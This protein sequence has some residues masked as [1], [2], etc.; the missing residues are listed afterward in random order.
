MFVEALTYRMGPHTT[1]DDPTRYRDDAEL[2]HWRARDPIDRVRRYLES[3]GTDSSTFA[4]IDA[5]AEE[6]GAAVR[7]ACL[8]I[9]EPD[10]AE[11]F[12]KVYAEQTEELRSQQAEYVAWRQ[13]YG[14]VA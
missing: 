10:L 7:S 2:E 13:Q 8:A 9:P 4:T 5:E 3:V 11:W 12:D 1:S 6:L 14:G